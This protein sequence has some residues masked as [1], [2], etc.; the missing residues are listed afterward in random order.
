MNDYSVYSYELRIPP[1]ETTFIAEDQM[2]LVDKAKAKAVFDCLFGEK[3]NAILVQRVVDSEVK[4]DYPCTVMA[5]DN[6]VVLLRLEKEK[7]VPLMVKSHGNTL[8]DPIVREWR[9]SNPF[10]YVFLDNRES[11]DPMRGLLI[12]QVNREAWPNPDTARNVLQ[13]SLNRWMER[14]KLALQVVLH[15]QLQTK[16]FWEHSEEYIRKK[17]RRVS[18]MTI[19]FKSGIIKESEKAL[20]KSSPYLRALLREPWSATGGE[21]TLDE[22]M[23]SKIIDKRKHDI[24]NILILIKSNPDF[25]LIISYD[26]GVTFTCG[27]DSCAYYPA[28]DEGN[29]I[30]F[31][32]EQKDENLFKYGIETWL[33]DIVELIKDFRDADPVKRKANRKNK[34]QPAA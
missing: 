2:K 17:K 19:R 33:D 23:G 11:T 12:V 28:P 9:R 3:G 10:S 24:E 22:P 15:S 14:Q 4:A 20:I 32:L 21:V 34:R 5:H 13:E 29:L 27:V 1:V 6:R 8:I 26:N 25:G 7:D 31:M 16:D 18:K 30:N